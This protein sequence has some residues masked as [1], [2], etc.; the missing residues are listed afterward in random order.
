MTV[1]AADFLAFAD[2]LS[3]SSAE[4][5]LRNCISRAYYSIFH[6]ALPVAEAHFPDQNANFKMGSHVRL[7][8]RF[9]CGKT[10]QSIGVAYVLEVTKRAR[11]RADYDLDDTIDAHDA[12]QQ[13]ASARAFAGRLA[14]CTPKTAPAAN[15]SVASAGGKP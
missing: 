11:H 2:A 13:L 5:D 15:A 9:H 12:Q 4:I 6:S 7:S 14:L 3:G 8:E 1:S 10:K